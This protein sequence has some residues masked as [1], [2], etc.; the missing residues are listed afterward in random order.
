MER[1]P[2]S[3]M[4]LCMLLLTAISVCAKEC[5]RAITAEMRANALV[6]V[7]RFEWAATRQRAAVTAAERW[8]AKSDDELWEMIPSQELPRGACTNRE[9]GCPN[10]GLDIMPFGHYPWKDA[11]QWKL[12]CPNCEETYPKNDF[13]AFYQS[14]LDEHGFFRRELGDKSLLFNAEHPDPNDPLHRIFVDDGYGLTD[15]EGHE[16]HFIAY[17]NE[18]FH[19]LRIKEA[20]RVLANAYSLTSEPRYAHKAAVLLDRLADVYPDMDW[21]PFAQLGFHHSD[22]HSGKG[23]IQGSIWEANRWAEAYSYDIIF[24]GIQ[25][26]MELVAFLSRK[27]AECKLSDKSSIAAICRHIEDDFIMEVLESAKDNR[28]RPNLGVRKVCVVRSAIALDRPGVSEEW[29]DWCFTPEFPGGQS[30]PWLLTEGIDRDG[31][32]GECGNYGLIWTRQ[33]I[34]FSDILA[35]YPDYTKH[36]IVAEY[37]KLKQCFLVEP[38]LMCLD[39]AFPPYGDSGAAGQWGRTG[40]IN[41]FVLGYRL[42]GDQRL[43][44]LAWRYAKGNREALRLADDIFEEDPDALVD[45]IVEAAKPGEFTLQCDH[46]G[47][48]G[49]LILQTE[50]P[51][52]ANGRAIWMAY[53]YNLG[54]RHRDALNLG[55]YAKNIDMLPDLGYPE[56]CTSYWPKFH[57]WTANTISH[58]TLLIDDRRN[59]ANNGG[60]MTLFACQPPVRV[61]EVSA[62]NVYEGVDTYRRTVALVDISDY[63]S[64]VLDVFRA[65]G[66]SN[67]RLSYHGPA[68]IATV[69]GLALVR[70]PSGTFAGEDVDFAALPSEDETIYNTSGFSYLYDVERSV[71]PVS[72]YYT[73]D[74]LAEDRRN[75]IQQGQEPHLRLH[76]LTSTDEVVLASG[77]PPQNQPNTPRRL[78]YLIQSRL[79]ENMSSQFVTVLEPYETTPFITSVRALQVTHDADPDSV[80]AVA[81]ELADGTVDILISC[82]QRTRVQ[83]EGGVQ[84]DGRFGMV[85]LVGGQVCTMRMS[86]AT[87]L[88]CGDVTL[89]LDI[90]AYEGTVT[91]ISADDPMDHRISLDP[92]LP[93]GDVLVGQRIH[94]DNGLPLDTTYEIKAVTPE[95]I[96]TGEMTIIQGFADRKDYGAGFR[97]LVNVGDRFVVP[98]HAGID[99]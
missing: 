49:Q 82:E 59:S 38:R 60:K 40:S 62:P 4:V 71:G 18:W 58:N 92:P 44:D 56:H 80:A 85:R 8:M 94:F 13:G 26:D 16:H 22:G 9:V 29:I 93:Q 1:M 10:C 11:G 47:R 51:D 86:D 74:W 68:Q 2:M 99:R 20:I 76:A 23:R 36:N 21:A 95:S 52:P 27:A 43:A 89:Q 54:H 14:S 90:P 97:Y 32:G 84:F 72:S 41:T 15:T 7:E 57:A 67:H 46:L 70:Q 73:V 42:Y 66:G 69:D 98:N 25:E 64:Y 31:M 37:P 28:I 79:G 77:D 83:V 48:Y 88:T 39:A 96:S 78:R 81:V 87:L 63:D 19:W 6:N 17:Y 5:S 91:A 55:L 35:Q 30:L 34:R 3:A 50:K 12:Q 33:M 53:G 24:D 65:K 45:A 75:R 61:A